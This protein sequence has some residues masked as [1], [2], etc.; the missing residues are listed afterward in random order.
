MA[1]SSR[2][3]STIFPEE[4]INMHL[5]WRIPMSDQ[6]TDNMN[7][8]AV[9]GGCSCHC[10]SSEL[11]TLNLGVL[12][13]PH[14]S[15]DDIEPA[16]ESYALEVI[17]GKKREKIHTNAHLQH[18][19]DKLLPKAIKYLHQNAESKMY[20]MSLKSRHGTAHLCVE[21]GSIQ[22]QT[23]GMLPHMLRTKGQQLYSKIESD[24][25]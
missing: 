8:T 17:D 12:L 4:V 22:I 11:P 25:S 23:A 15:S 5:K 13:I 14:E 16:V 21:K 3:L 10:Q 18:L 6:G 9:R 7:L 19:G 24:G 20:Q 2:M 1:S